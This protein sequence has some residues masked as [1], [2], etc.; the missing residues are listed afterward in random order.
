[1]WPRARTRCRATPA[2]GTCRPSRGAAR[3]SAPRPASPG[4]P[5]PRPACRGARDVAWGR[6][7][8]RQE[9]FVVAHHQ[10]AVDLLHRLE[11]HTDRDEDRGAAEADAA[12][13]E[14]RERK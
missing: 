14:Q 2:R 4:C 12:D 5:C 10:L 9:T 11:H 3:R 6:P 13:V 1:A 7:C 8:L